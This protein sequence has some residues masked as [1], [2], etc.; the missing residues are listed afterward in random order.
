MLS[1]FHN[2]PTCAFLLAHGPEAQRSPAPYCLCI[3][4]HW[5]VKN[6]YRPPRGGGG[7]GGGGGDARY[8]TTT[9][10]I[11]SVTTARG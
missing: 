8:N 3:W 4:R 1:L 7:G 5:P 6:V 10:P 2:L 11:L 9:F